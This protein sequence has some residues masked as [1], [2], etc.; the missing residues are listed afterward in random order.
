MNWILGIFAFLRS[1]PEILR[2][3]LEVRKVVR[4][5]GESKTKKE[6]AKML[7][8]ALREARKTG[9]FTKIE[10]LFNAEKQ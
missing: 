6:R 10:E 2:L 1:L 7:H 3:L 4:D 5:I 9:D 8:E